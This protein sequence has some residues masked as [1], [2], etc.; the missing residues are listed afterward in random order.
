MKNKRLIAFLMILL[1]NNNWAVAQEI[2]GTKIKNYLNNW[3][4][5]ST[6]APNKHIFSLLPSSNK[7]PLILQTP[8][9]FLQQNHTRKDYNLLQRVDALYINYEYT[10]KNNF[11]VDCGFKYLKYWT[12]Y[13]GN[14]GLMSAGYISESLS[15]YSTY[16]FD[17][18]T[19]YKI[20]VNDNIKLLNVHTG[21]SLGITNNKIGNYGGNY[22]ISSY[23]DGMGN[24]GEFAITSSYAIKNRTNL[25]FYLGLS[26][27]F[28]VTENLYLSAR[29]H[30]H[31]GEKSIIS[32][33]KINYS[34]STYGIVEEVRANLTAKGKMYA[35]GLRWVF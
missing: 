17:V 3:L 21:F 18:G 15:V 19:G 7:Y 32:E 8:S 31:F 26:K 4:T 12:G 6:I 25:G 13:T 22:S 1:V 14:L 28:R 20:I 24:P 34:L 5:N 16:S 33:H 11:F 2:D 30:N 29:F 35:V 23:L 10:L 27:D 9:A